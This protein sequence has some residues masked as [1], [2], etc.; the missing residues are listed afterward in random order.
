MKRRNR[1]AVLSDPAKTLAQ[2]GLTARGGRDARVTGLSVDSREVQ[3]GHLFAAL[4]GTRVHG[5]DFIQYAL[6][7]GA[8]AILTDAQGA[9]IAAQQLAESDAA[10]R[11]FAEAQA[12]LPRPEGA[13]RAVGA[14]R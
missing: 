6:R 10:L 2:L 5:G 4:P 1:G 9:R 12:H 8:S 11:R 13:G 14:P 3:P 7:M